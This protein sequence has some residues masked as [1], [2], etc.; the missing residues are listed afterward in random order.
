MRQKPG[1]RTMRFSATQRIAV[2]RVA[3]SW[4]A[5]FPLLGPFAIRVVDG[6]ADGQ[7]R[8][9]GR[10]LGLPVQ[11]QSGP[12]I[13]SGEVL[14]Y[15]AELPWAPHAMV[16][17]PELDWRPLGERRVEVATSVA[18][19]RLTVEMAFDEAGDIVRSSSQMRLFR[20]GDEWVPTPWAGEFSQYELLGG[21]RIPTAAEVY[22]NLPGGRFVYWRGRVLSAAL[23]D[24]A[25]RE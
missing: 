22:W 1:A 24:R 7:G 6:F 14:R 19:E 20:I 17:N 16:H 4:Q 21:I 9:E 23:L 15:L 8:L 2:D 12:Q 25:G 18:G 10:A 5:S 3:F 11:R 13:T